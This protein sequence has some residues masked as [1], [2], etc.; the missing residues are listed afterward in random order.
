MIERIRT[1]I[2]DDERYSREELIYLLKRILHSRSLEKR[3]P[4]TGGVKDHAVEA[5]SRVSGY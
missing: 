4:G 5:G 2:V 3:I 1:L